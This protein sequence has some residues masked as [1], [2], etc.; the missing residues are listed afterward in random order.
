MDL[1]SQLKNCKIIDCS[2]PIDER[3]TVWPGG[4]A[5]ERCPFREH[6]KDGYSKQLYNMACDVGLFFLETHFLMARNTY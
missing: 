6:D 2:Q 1:L 3:A 5:F 4:I